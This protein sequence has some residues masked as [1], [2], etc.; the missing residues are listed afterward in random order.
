[1]NYVEN[2]TEKE[3][4]GAYFSK[5]KINPDEIESFCFMQN[6]KHS[7]LT[8][9][10]RSGE[11]R[12]LRPHK[13]QTEVLRYLLDRQ[14]PFSN[15]TQPKKSA[16]SIPEKNYRS[17]PNILF[18][19]FLV[20]VLLVLGYTALTAAPQ[21][22]ATADTPKSALIYFVLMIWVAG[23]FLT[24]Y[25]LFYKCH[26]LR[27]TREGLILKNCFSCQLLPYD[28]IRKINFSL[29]PSKQPR[30]FI[31]WIDRDFRYHCYLLGWMPFKS[32][33]GLVRQ[34]QALGIDATDSVNQ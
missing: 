29:F 3:K 22:L 16:V 5:K 8:L 11:T 34:L 26:R 19:V 6:Y 23:V 32:I 1:M 14:I 27:T 21:S 10:L 33:S 17:I 18:D 7:A 12:E 2:N 20:A 24:S 13:I 31:E 28:E 30:A 9:Q 15:Y 25:Y 4:A